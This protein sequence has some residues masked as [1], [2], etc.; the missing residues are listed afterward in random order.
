MD[1]VES[2]YA[3]T[4]TFPK[5]EEYRLVSQLHRAVV[6]IPTN[7]AEGHSRS[8]RRDYASFVSIARGSAA[9]LET[10][11]LIAQ[12]TKCAKREDIAPRLGA[13]E[14]IGRML[15]GLRSKLADR[16]S[17]QSQNPK[18]K[19][20]NPEPMNPQHRTPRTQNP[21]PKTQTP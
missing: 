17:P 11:L 13:A 2:V 19:T 3:L 4:K 5:Q 9:E 18:P 1:L 8:T 16:V 6:S 7:L 20:V 14:R 15:N 12:R 21:E 10:L